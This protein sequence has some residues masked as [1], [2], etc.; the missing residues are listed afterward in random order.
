MIKFCP[1]HE[2]PIN[3]ITEKCAL[4]EEIRQEEEQSTRYA[5]EAED[6]ARAESGEVVADKAEA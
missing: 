6:D 2:C 1:I 4:C 5:R 3:A